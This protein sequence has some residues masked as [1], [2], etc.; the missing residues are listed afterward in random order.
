M[1]HSEFTELLKTKKILL[2]EV[3]SYIK[4]TRPG[5]SSALDNETIELRKIKLICELI[6]ESPAIFF[7][8]GSFGILPTGKKAEDYEK[9]IDYLKKSLKDKEDI[10]N[11]LREKDSGYRIASEQSSTYELGKKSK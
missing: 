5:L 6:R 1:K 8:K 7:D 3:L 2:K 11:L 10:I 9:E 4:M